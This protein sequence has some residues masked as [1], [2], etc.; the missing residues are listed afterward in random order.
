MTRRGVALKI[1]TPLALAAM[2]A[3]TLAAVAES[4]CRSS[5]G[6][7]CVNL[8]A[9]NFPGLEFLGEAVGLG[10]LIA[11][12]YVWGLGFVG[13]SAML[14]FIYG[15]VRYMV[16]GDRDPSEAKK[17]MTNAV[18][19][20]VVALLSWL[21]LFTIN[22]DLVTNLIPDLYKIEAPPVTETTGN[23]GGPPSPGTKYKCF[24]AAVNMCVP[25]TYNTLADCQNECFSGTCRD[26][27]TCP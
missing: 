15:G 2:P 6:G 24:N 5:T 9:V 17:A 23:E 7:Y 10:D 16:A 1:L 18:I 8:A 12:L 20:L 13:V 27:T 4:I 19:G 21:I 3:A 14:V 26:V 22:P 25:L 11:R